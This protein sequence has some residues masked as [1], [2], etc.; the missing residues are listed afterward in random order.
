MK[1]LV[2]LDGLAALAHAPSH[3]LCLAEQHANAVLILLNVQ[4]AETLPVG[5]HARGERSDDGAIR[6]YSS[7]FDIGD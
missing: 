1:L 4:N 2:P 3:A 7:A 6:N 5:N